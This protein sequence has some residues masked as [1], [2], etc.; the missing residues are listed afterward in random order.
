MTFTRPGYQYVTV[1]VHGGQVRR[2][3]IDHIC[4]LLGL[5]D[6]KAVIRDA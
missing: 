4:N 6:E 3:Y 1:P 5:D 2:V